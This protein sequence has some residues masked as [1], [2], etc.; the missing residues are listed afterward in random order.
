MAMPVPSWTQDIDN[1]YTS[2]WAYR[3][4][5]AIEQAFLKTPFIFWLKK[6]GQAEGI[7]GHRR[8]E[9]PLDYGRNETIRWI[10]KGDTVPIQDSEMLTM[11]YE[12]W[13][14][15]AVS[16]VRWFTED[17]QNRGKAQA[18]NLVSTKLNAAERE[19]WEEFE[20]VMFADGT[21]SNEPNGLQNLVSSTPTTGTVHGLNR[22]TY[23]WWQNQQKT[24]SGAAAVYLVPDMRTCLNDIVKYSRAEISDI[25][26]V[27]TQA[28]FEL[29]ED[30]CLEMKILSNTMMA[31]AGFDS[32]QFK[33][34][35]IMWC[36]SAP[37]GKM[38]FL[39]TKNIKLVYDDGYFMEMTDWKQI[40][41]QP[42]DKVAQI[43]CAMN[44]ITN[45]P[46][47]LKVMDSIAA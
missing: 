18:I 28:V 4:K 32:I 9:I 42:F 26:L 34:R 15:V 30:V 22:A 14:Y 7:S 36:P 6:K 38:Y 35:P 43:V 5:E 8:I 40:P 19:I 12:D 10:T 27:T 2:T 25:A 21:G 44:L 37:S 47:V 45:R 39:N 3:K 33:G 13:K 20:R 17:Q 11:A 24:A 41:D 31:D 23:D 16:I 46:V 29:Y 1:L